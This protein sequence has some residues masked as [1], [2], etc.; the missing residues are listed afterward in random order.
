MFPEGKRL[1]RKIKYSP[2][3]SSSEMI[4]S[5]WVY[6]ELQQK[7]RFIGTAAGHNRACEISDNVI[8]CHQQSSLRTD[9]KLQTHNKY[10]MA[11][12]T[13]SSKLLPGDEGDIWKSN[14][15]NCCRFQL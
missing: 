13:E 9:Q 15:Q 5:Y 10:T 8:K 14:D 7:T 3:W 6:R 2:S 11:E 4:P 12:K 1:V